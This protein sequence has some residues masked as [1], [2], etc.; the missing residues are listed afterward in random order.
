M[1]R[2][3]RRPGHAA[4][5]LLAIRAVCVGMSQSFDPEYE[6]NL[7]AAGEEA[8]AA[9]QPPRPRSLFT[10]AAM[11]AGIII[12]VVAAALGLAALGGLK[13]GQ[14]ERSLRATQT[15]TAEI[16][17]QF[18]LG[19]ADLE[20][21]RYQLAEERLVYVI[22]RVPDYPGAAERLAEA[23]RLL[24][25]TQ[26]PTETALPPSEASTMDERFAEAR[27]FYEDEQWEAAIERL[28]EIEA[29]DPSYRTVEVRQMLYD[30][31]TTLG[32]AYVRGDRIEEGILLLDQA[33]K[34]RPLDDQTEGERLLASFYIM[35]KTYWG[36][37]WPVVIQNFE[38]IYEV[39]P[40]YRDVEDR[41]WKAY[42]RYADQLAA[43]GAQCDAANQYQVALDFRPDDEI[44]KKQEEAT[45]AC[46]N[47]TPT[48]SPTSPFGEPDGTSLPTDETN[49]IPDVTPMPDS[50]EGSEPDDLPPPGDRP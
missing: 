45:E 10:S 50:P 2:A 23:R 17:N 9:Q 33:A 4:V 37:N 18:Q 38:A 14:N 13:A 3:R 46:L 20:A 34:I 12:C 40:F 29:L 8:A 36:L 15:T 11:V 39:A 16:D 35:G 26:T 21:G 42:V 48:P 31:L 6:A 44:Q 47:P 49:T 5:R 22:S 1:R 28:Q 30:A 24:N 19:L 25:V 27:A 43:I 32:L 41:L 7:S